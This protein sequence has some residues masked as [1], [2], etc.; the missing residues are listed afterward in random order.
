MEE[1]ARVKKDGLDVKLVQVAQVLLHVKRAQ[2]FSKKLG[3]QPA[4]ISELPLPPVR[5]ASDKPSAEE[6]IESDR[7][8]VG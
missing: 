1:A 3:P 2:N 4:S 7:R 5:K 6:L 8:A